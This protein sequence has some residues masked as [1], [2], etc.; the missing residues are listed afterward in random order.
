M[1]GASGMTVLELGIPTGFE[2]DAESVVEVSTLKKTE[3]VDR[4]VIFYFDKV[5]LYYLIFYSS[6]QSNIIYL[7]FFFFLNRD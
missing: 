1:S 7:D 5:I 4:K 6:E 3:T 2:L